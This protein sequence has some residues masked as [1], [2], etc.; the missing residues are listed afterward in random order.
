MTME[1]PVKSK[2]EFN[3]LHVGD[4]IQATV[5][6]R[7]EGDYDLSDIQKQAPGK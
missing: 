6:V 3:A 1:Y 2:S 5:N 7:R 4:R